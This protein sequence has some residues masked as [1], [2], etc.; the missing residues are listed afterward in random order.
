MTQYELAQMA[1]RSEPLRMRIEYLMAKAGTV[2][3]RARHLAR[4]AHPEA[5]RIDRLLG[6]RRAVQ[7]EHRRRRARDRW[8]HDH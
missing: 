5:H 8:Q 3:R 6:T 4:A 1:L 2:A 7:P